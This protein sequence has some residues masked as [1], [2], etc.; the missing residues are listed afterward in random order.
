VQGKKQVRHFGKTRVGLEGAGTSSVCHTG[1]PYRSTL[2]HPPVGLVSGYKSPQ[3]SFYLSPWRTAIVLGMFINFTF[4]Q[5][6]LGTYR[7]GQSRGGLGAE[8]RGA[9]GD[10][11]LVE[12]VLPHHLGGDEG[13]TSA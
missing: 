11:C 2:P 4:S 10:H 13:S 3:I 7:T 8:H 5:P 6:L 1:Q 12:R 9:A